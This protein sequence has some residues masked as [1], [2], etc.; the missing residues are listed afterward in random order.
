MYVYI[1]ID[2]ETTGLDTRK[3]RVIS[4]AARVLNNSLQ[5]YPAY[6]EN[7]DLHVSPNTF[8]CF[9]HPF[10]SNHAVNINN[11]QDSFLRTCFPFDVYIKAF[12][13]WICEVSGTNNEIVFIGHNF[14]YFDETMLLAELSRTSTFS[15]IP[16]NK[17][18]FKIDTM[19]LFRYVFPL[20]TKSIPYGLPSTIDAP[21]SYKQ[22]DVY[23][24]LFKKKPSNQHDALGDVVA[25]EEILN[26][27][28]FKNLIPLATPEFSRIQ[29]KN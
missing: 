19:K 2:L 28:I 21:E 22:V 3:D 14:D 25:L 6:V 24:F 15:Y 29:F 9:V 16:Q 13:D 18:F 4:L 1:L 26:T 20:T 27:D 8:H 23:S 11:L 10:M 7:H 12:W 17:Q 5:D